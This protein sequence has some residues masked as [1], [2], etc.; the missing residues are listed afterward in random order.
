MAKYGA[1]AVV[2]L[3]GGDNVLEALPFGGDKDKILAEM[4]NSTRVVLC[5]LFAAHPDVHVHQWG[6]DLLS[7]SAPEYCQGFG[8]RTSRPDQLATESIYM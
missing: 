8:D 3:I 4:L 2:F 1:Q 5:T 7:W 6:Y